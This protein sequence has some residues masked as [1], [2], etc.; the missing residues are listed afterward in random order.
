M[1]GESVGGTGLR[2]DTAGLLSAEV[3]QATLGLR[4]GME[5]LEV[6]ETVAGQ[7]QQGSLE[8]R[9]I[10]ERLVVLACLVEMEVLARIG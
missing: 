1:Q 4:V 6:M 2:R 5:Y 9:D 3:T 10:L 7:G 8:K